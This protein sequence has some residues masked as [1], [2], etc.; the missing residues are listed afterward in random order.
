MTA[1]LHFPAAPAVFVAHGWTTWLDVPIRHPRVFWYVAV[2][3]VTRDTLVRRHGIPDERI[4]LIP[5]FVDVERFAARR[6]LPPAPRRAL[7][8]SH[9][10]REDTHLPVVR[11]ACQRR[12]LALDVLGYG[13]GRP[14]NDPER[15]LHDYDIVFAKGRAALE[16]VATGAAVIV[17]DTFGVGPMVT[18]ENVEAL[19]TLE[20]DFLQWLSPLSVTA[21]LRQIDKYDPRDA[22]AV[23]A[24]VRGV[25][26]ADRVVPELA[27]L[28]ALARAEADA[29]A[30]DPAR[31]AQAAA[32]YLRWLSTY[33]KERFVERDPLAGAAVRLRNRLTRIPLLASILL[34]VSA[35]IHARIARR[36]LPLDCEQREDTHVERLAPERDR[37]WES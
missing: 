11:D 27:A 30:L 14:V 16:A 31:E 24:Q 2:D 34:R 23:T 36:R 21:L 37:S 19:R 9:Y 15:R 1:L 12:G 6:S 32:A 28:Y 26:A 22:A 13:V 8:L 7:V 25:A 35:R 17:C 3:G 20:G 18:S 29:A 10:A 5:N 4:R 33:V